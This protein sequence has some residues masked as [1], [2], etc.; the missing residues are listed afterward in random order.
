MRRRDF[1]HTIVSTAFRP[2]DAQA[3]R[4]LSI[5]GFLS[6]APMLHAEESFGSF[7]GEL[8]VKALP[9]GRD[10][11][12]MGPFSYIDPAGKLWA[13]P[14]GTIVDGASIPQVFW[15][16]IGGPFEGKYREASVVHDYY[17]DQKSDAWQNVHL[18]F[19]NG[20]RARGVAP[21]LAKLMYAAVYNFGPRWIEVSSRHPGKLISGQPILLD[22]VKEAITR[23]VSENDP[24][25][26]AIRAMSAQITQFE[27]IEQ[28]E[29]IVYEH[30][31]CTP[32]LPNA[33]EAAILTNATNPQ[34]AM[35]KQ[36]LILCGLSAA[37]KKQA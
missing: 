10:L 11:Q 1:L 29:K 17:C 14:A 7:Q 22:S 25:L 23:F 36:T 3:Q 18:V 28:L 8:I 9:G 20:M 33:P 24:S 12:L 26:P 27:S 6:S 13:V 19:Y 5:I 4:A 34:D 31:N 15:S 16:I 2:V 37:S 35:V 30:A 21:L 32:I